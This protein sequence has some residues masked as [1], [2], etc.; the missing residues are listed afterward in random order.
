MTLIRAIRRVCQHITRRLKVY[1]YHDGASTLLTVEVHYLGK[2]ILW[3]GAWVELFG[4][5]ENKRY[6]V[7]SL[8]AMPSDS[9]RVIVYLHLKSDEVLLTGVKQMALLLDFQFGHYKE[10]QQTLTEQSRDI[11]WK[12]KLYPKLLLFLDIEETVGALTEASINL[13]IC[14]TTNKAWKA[15]DRE[16]ESFEKV[17]H[18]LYR[19]FLK[20]LELAP[21]ISVSYP[22]EHRKTDRYFWGSQPTPEQNIFSAALDAVEINNLILT[23]D[24]NIC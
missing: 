9:S 12:A 4:A 23:I 18:P 21:F 8:Q 6:Q 20:E 3:E 14:T 19:L 24:N 1:E 15:L 2:G 11:E 17:L 16:V 13:A 22:I 7:R 5:N 10:I